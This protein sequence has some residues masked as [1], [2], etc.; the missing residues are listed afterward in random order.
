MDSREYTPQ[1]PLGEPHTDEWYGLCI[2]AA[3]DYFMTTSAYVPSVMPDLSIA[4]L[5]SALLFVPIAWFRVNQD[6]M[7]YIDLVSQVARVLIA[8]KA[9]QFGS[10]R[11]RMETPHEE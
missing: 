2:D 1:N 9:G 4:E 11:E 8:G 7:S 3:H 10:P 5:K 6:K